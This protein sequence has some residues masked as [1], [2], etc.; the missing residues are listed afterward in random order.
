MS[1]TPWR[2]KGS[3]AAISGAEGANGPNEDRVVNFPVS[4]IS[5]RPNTSQ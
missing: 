2:L 3:L 1:V 4:E 5:P